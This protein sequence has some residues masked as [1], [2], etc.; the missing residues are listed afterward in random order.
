M[1]FGIEASGGVGPGPIDHILIVAITILLPLHDLIFWF[2]RLRRAT[3]PG[4]GRA[5]SRAYMESAIIEWALVILVLFHWM[6]TRR[7]VT[8]LGF[9]PPAGWRF[10]AASVLVLA[11]LGFTTWQRISLTRSTE[12]KVRREVMAQLEHLRPL[13]PH[14]RR[15]M[16]RFVLLSMTAGICEEVLFRGYLLWYLSCLVPVVAAWMAG[17]LLFGMAHAYQGSGGV[18]R[19]GLVGAGLVALY[20]ISG[21]L[22]LPMI[23]HAYVDVN[24]GLLAYAYLKHSESPEPAASDP[25]DSQ[26]LPL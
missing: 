22:W 14:T 18:L 1:T 5:R 13:L 3:G 25:V 6:S 23:L 10:W 26:N 8:G 16:I 11:A 21:S 24:S 19:T 12:H 9:G 7:P 17:A 15:E 4:L 2:P 20:L